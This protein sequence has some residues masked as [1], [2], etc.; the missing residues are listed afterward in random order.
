MLVRQGVKVYASVR[1]TQTSQSEC[2][3]HASTAV[4]QMKGELSFRETYGEAVP[5][6]ARTRII[7]P[8]ARTLELPLLERSGKVWKGLAILSFF[9][10]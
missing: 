1:R 7:E 8:H 5:S 9:S 3:G 2:I 10:V 6:T 4:P